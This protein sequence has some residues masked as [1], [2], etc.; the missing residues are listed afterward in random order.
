MVIDLTGDSDS[1][2][3]DKQIFSQ[4][5]SN[6]QSA[7]QPAPN[8]FAHLTH[9][10]PPSSVPLKRRLESNPESE[11]YDS[12]FHF[13][14]KPSAPLVGS[15]AASSSG[16][17]QK[18]HN[19]R[20]NNYSIATELQLSTPSPT[21]VTREPS[22]PIQTISV[23]VPS[24][25]QQLRQEIAS[26]KW[27]SNSPSCTPEPTGVSEKFYPTNAHVER[28]EK[29]AYPRARRVNRAAIPLPIGKPGPIL[30][31][32]PR[33]LDRQYRTLE[34][35]LSLVKGPEVTVAPADGPKLAKVTANFE[36]INSY[37]L[38]KGVSPAPAEFIGGC[39]CGK[40]CD[41]KRC[42]CSEKEDDS[43]DNII[44][45][46]QA[47]DRPD[48]LVLTPEFLKRSTM[49]LECGAQCAC[50]RRCW[51]RVVQRGRTVELEIFHTGVRGFGLRS[52]SYIRAGQFIDCYLGEVIT[53]QRADIREEIAVKSGHSYL[54]GLDFSP[55]VDEEDIYVVDGQRFGNATRF[56]NH[57]CKPNCRMFTVTNTIGDERLYNLAFF[58]LKDIPPMT[59]LT[60]DYNPGAER[61]KQVDSSVVACLCG[62][63]NCRG[64]LWPSKRKGTK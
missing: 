22:K 42:P 35:K 17:L 6:I 10:P 40:Y 2:D 55:E 50:D 7:T 36:F 49:I 30:K 19:G 37:K 23:V 47:R 1:E 20:L 8:F 39:S 43:A 26:A 62:E 61:S 53:K 13:R 28:A 12:F 57:S 15:S 45:Y 16:F 58:A 46:Q 32:R 14:K 38:H 59:E 27:A 56:M 54:F 63:N 31:K 51:N 52:P 48:L 5:H 29:G 18:V 60:F 3:Q 25:S 21:P 64:Q 44:P 4:L 11:L 41:P 33:A 34:R 24:P 9:R